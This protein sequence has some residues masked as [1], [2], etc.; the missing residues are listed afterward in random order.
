MWLYFR[1][2]LSLR[3]VEELMAARGIGV[4]Y[5]TFRCWTIKFPYRR[6]AARKFRSGKV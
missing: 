6:T 5:E 4:S 3:D 2:S 1:F